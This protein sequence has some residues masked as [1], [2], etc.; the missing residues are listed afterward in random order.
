MDQRSVPGVCAS[1]VLGLLVSRAVQAGTTDVLTLEDALAQARA[2]SPA[3]RTATADITAARGRLT[4]AGA[5]PNPIIAGELARHAV[6][7]EENIDRGV[8]L[9]QEIEVGGQRGLR[10]TAAQH[11]VERARLALAD[12]ERRVAAAVRHAFFGLAAAQQRHDI[13]RDGMTLAQQLMNVARQRARAGEIADYDANV[14]QI[15]FAQAEQGYTQAEA[16]RVDAET[17]LATLLGT[18]LDEHF[19]LGTATH[20]DVATLPSEDA[21]V[22]RAIAERPDLAALRAERRQHEVEAD[23]AHRRGWVPNPTVRGFYRHEQRDETIAGGE[24]SVPLPL[25]NR[26]QGAEAEL[27]ALTSRAASEG[28]RLTREVR[29]QVHVAMARHHAAAAIWKHFVETVLPTVSEAERILVT[30]TQAGDL[31]LHDA[32]GERDRLLAVRATAIT[33]WL[34]WHEAETDLGEAVGKELR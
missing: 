9:S 22:E 4:R 18:P 11:D 19:R 6:P 20:D 32:L 25:W 24:I 5:Y 26:E 23:L 1:W 29:Q 13:A 17:R 33:A 16:A 2:Q 8:S 12:Q 28:D 15:A 34:D 10:M 7:P 30:R 31:S 27:R 21:L 3:L 14:A